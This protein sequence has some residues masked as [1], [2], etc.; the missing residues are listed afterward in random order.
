MCIRDRREALEAAVADATKTAVAEVREREA[1]KRAAARPV[2]PRAAIAFRVPEACFVRVARFLY[3]APRPPPT[4][5]PLDAGILE[6]LEG[7]VRRPPP[8]G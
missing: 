8:P 2:D 5:L 4:P 7:F 3:H 6:L 1:V